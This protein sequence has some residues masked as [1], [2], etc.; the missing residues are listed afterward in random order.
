MNVLLVTN[1]NKDIDFSFS[2]EV[3]EYLKSKD[4]TLYS[5]DEELINHLRSK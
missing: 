3:V 4:I 2:K 5:D 1:N